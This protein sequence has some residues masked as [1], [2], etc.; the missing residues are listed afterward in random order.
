MIRIMDPPFYLQRERKEDRN[1]D[2][3]PSSESRRLQN[4]IRLNYT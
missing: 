4:T 3:L 2:E 1:N